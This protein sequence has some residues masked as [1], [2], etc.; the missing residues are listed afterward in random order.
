MNGLHPMAV[1]N[2]TE[3]LRILTARGDT[4]EFSYRY[5]SWVQYRSRR[6]QPRV[7]LDPLA[8]ELSELEPA[9]SRWEFEGV[10]FLIPR[11]FLVGSDG[12]ALSLGE[13]REHLEAHLAGAA[14]AWDPYS[15]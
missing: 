8:A 2:A 1:H 13:F 11:L 4:Y 3:R 7:D 12:S 14:I 10:D 9:G 5:E 15:A 6:P